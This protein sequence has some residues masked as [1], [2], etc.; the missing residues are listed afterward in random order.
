MESSELKPALSLNDAVK[1]NEAAKLMGC[2][3]ESLLREAA[4]SERLLYVAINPHSS[5]LA[6][7]PSHPTPRQG[8]Y[9]TKAHSIVAMLP[10]Y[11]ESLAIAG[12]AEIAQYQAG[13]ESPLD[14]H[15]WILDEPQTVGLESVYVPSHDPMLK[16]GECSQGNAAPTILNQSSNDLEFSGLLNNPSKKDD[17]FNVIDDM[18]KDFY[19]KS[20]KIP[21]ETQAWVSLWTSSPEGYEITTGKDKGDDC[22][23]MP[24][25]KP[26][27]KSAFSKRWT[28]YTTNKAQ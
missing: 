12:S 26:L 18:A 16:D 8:T 28:N 9:A 22:L 25:A 2:T 27:S 19:T 21:N 17:W 7:I 14:W 11:A 6:A 4:S 23:Y 10:H 3:V 20:N 5:T 24:G 15:Y 13:F 1:I